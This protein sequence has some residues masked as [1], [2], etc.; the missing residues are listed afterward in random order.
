M[1]GYG[2]P[3]RTRVAPAKRFVAGVRRTGGTFRLALNG[4]HEMRRRIFNNEWHGFFVTFSCLQ[5][6]KAIR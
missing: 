2:F 1:E 5:E 3:I 6:R 4:V